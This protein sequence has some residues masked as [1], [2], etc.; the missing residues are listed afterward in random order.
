MKNTD[1]TIKNT[2]IPSKTPQKS[3][4]SYQNTLKTPKPLKNAKNTHF[5]SKT[6]ILLSKTTISISKTPQKHHFPMKIPSKTPIFLLKPPPIRSPSSP[7]ADCH[8]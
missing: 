5:L 6:P 3:P 4:F 7:W 1:F 2:H 8:F